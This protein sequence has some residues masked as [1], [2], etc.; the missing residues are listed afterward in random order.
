MD[1]G[2]EESGTPEATHGRRD[3]HIKINGVKINIGGVADGGTWHVDGAR[4]DRRPHATRGVH[5]STQ[6]CGAEILSRCRPRGR[7]PGNGTRRAVSTAKP[8]RLSGKVSAEVKPF[9][10]LP[11]SARVCR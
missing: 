10:A 6:G 1:G 7:R 8:L 5:G 2:I 3:P 9:E 4:A 11:R